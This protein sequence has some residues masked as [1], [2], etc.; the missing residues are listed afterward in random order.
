MF[1][2]LEQLCK[3]KEKKKKLKQD[4]D[5]ELF[6]QSFIW[7]AIIKLYRQ[8][9]QTFINCFGSS[10]HKTSELMGDLHSAQLYMSTYKT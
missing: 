10:G 2:Y 8:H 9:E 1:D 5:N 3:R 7:L 6:L 4:I